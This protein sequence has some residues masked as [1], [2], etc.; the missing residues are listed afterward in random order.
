[1]EHNLQESMHWL[2]WAR[3]VLCSGTQNIL[4]APHPSTQMLGGL[5]SDAILLNSFFLI[6]D[7]HFTNVD[8]LYVLYFIY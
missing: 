2:D 3:S 4:P 7:I 5:A 6:N 1:M 8:P